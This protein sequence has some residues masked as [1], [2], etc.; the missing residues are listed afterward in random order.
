MSTAYLSK[1]MAKT[2]IVTGAS[3]GIGKTSAIALSK[4]GW[5]VVLTARREAEL[6][7]TA[8]ECPTSTLVI[9]GDVTNPA[10]V[11]TLFAS[12]IEK[13]G[14]LDV[15]FNN[16]GIPGPQKQLD[17]IEHADLL[18]VL[19]VNVVASFLCTQEAFKIFK[20]QEPQG[21]RII[22]NGSIAAHVPRP[23]TAPY[24]ISKH[25]ISGLTKSTN[26][27]G[28]KYGITVTQ[29][30]IGNV[31]TEM[32]EKF[33]FGQGSLQPD[34]RYLR[35]PMIDRNHVGDTIVHIANLPTDVAMLE[36]NIMRPVRG[37]RVDLFVCPLV[38]VLQV[39]VLFTRR[40]WVPLLNRSRG[41]M[42]G[43]VEI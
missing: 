6:K 2:A 43:S 1:L 22:N 18:Q 17:E 13:Y 29:I 4:A 33:G 14:R 36:V 11:K 25:A 10:F 16:A 41:L 31:F 35:E 40:A 19:N 30:D 39:L 37:K 42:F 27:D 5:N 8:Q 7:S 9:P 24:A 28:R 15:L 3:S 21:G 20:S 34:G 32:A 12:T 26:L 38:I 23:N